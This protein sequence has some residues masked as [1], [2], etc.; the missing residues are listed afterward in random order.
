MREHNNPQTAI[1]IV[2]KGIH[3]FPV[4]PICHQSCYKNT[5]S[6]FYVEI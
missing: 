5:C 2:Y 4:F 1:D 6:K 3:V